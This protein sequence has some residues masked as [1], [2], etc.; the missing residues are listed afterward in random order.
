MSVSNVEASVNILSDQAIV[1]VKAG[2]YLLQKLI[3]VETAVALGA[4]SSLMKTERETLIANGSYQARQLDQIARDYNKAETKLKMSG[5]FGTYVLKNVR[6]DLLGLVHLDTRDADEYITS[7]SRDTDN[8]NHD[9]GLNYSVLTVELFKE[10]DCPEH[11]EAALKLALVAFE[12]FRAKGLETKCEDVTYFLS[13]NLNA[14]K[15]LGVENVLRK[16]GMVDS[17][18]VATEFYP[19]INKL[20][21]FHRSFANVG[22]SAFY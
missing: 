1:Q 5:V 16:V 11:F 8:K 20:R 15:I 22:P 2:N 17:K 9:F 6:N 3:P 14:W 12:R 21:V 4:N 7:T 13:E 10:A 19:E 18:R